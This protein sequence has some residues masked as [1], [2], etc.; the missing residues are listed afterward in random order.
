MNYWPLLGVAVVVAGFVARRN[1]ALVVVI[2]FALLIGFR[3]TT[4]PLEWLAAAGVLLLIAVSLTWV[5]VAMGTVAKSVETASNMPRMNPR[6][7]L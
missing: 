7:A 5:A 1:P 6:H 2:A 3:A 4:G